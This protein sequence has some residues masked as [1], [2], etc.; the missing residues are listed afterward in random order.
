M[1]SFRKHLLE[2][3]GE[4]TVTFPELELPKMPRHERYK[5]GPLPVISKAVILFIGVIT[6]VTHSFSAIY[7]GSNCIY[8]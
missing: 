1:K 4:R 3:S 8:I 7:R 5:V 2:N 6:P